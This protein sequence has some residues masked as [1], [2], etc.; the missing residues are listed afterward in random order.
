MAHRPYPLVVA[1]C[2]ACYRSLSEANSAVSIV[3]NKTAGLIVSAL[4]EFATKRNLMR[5][6]LGDTIALPAMAALIIEQLFHDCAAKP[7]SV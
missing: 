5:H 6:L 7:A 4:M 1:Q 3:R 2:N